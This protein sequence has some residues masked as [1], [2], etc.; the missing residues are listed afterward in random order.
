MDVVG[1]MGLPE[2][3]VRTGRSVCCQRGYGWCDEAEVDGD[4]DGFDGGS[5]G[6]QLG[7]S[8]E[9]LGDSVC[10]VAN[11]GGDLFVVVAVRFQLQDGPVELGKLKAELANG[12]VDDGSERGGDAISL[13]LPHLDT[14]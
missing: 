4:G 9:S 11:V 3:V 12:G 2:A 10:R 14:R 1:P 7:D 13:P 5:D 8:G 6:K